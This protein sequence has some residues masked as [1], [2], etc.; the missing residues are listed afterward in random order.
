MLY[1]YL[2]ERRTLKFWKKVTNVKVP[3]RAK[4]L[5]HLDFIISITEAIS[6]E[7]LQHKNGYRS[8]SPNMNDNIC[9][10]VLT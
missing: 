7:W 5:T 6:K 3:N 10:Y 4:P 9:V 1:Q 2:D 8:S